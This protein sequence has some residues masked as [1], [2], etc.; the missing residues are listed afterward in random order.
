MCE[1]E[2]SLNEWC[3]KL[4]P[5]HKVNKEL[6]ALRAKVAEL[7]TS[8]NNRSDVIFPFLE[9]ALQSAIKGNMSATVVTIQ[10]AME[11]LHTC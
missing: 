8:N 7:S 1:R 11:R 9:S 6:S 5:N 3:Q 2:M 10:H 4:S